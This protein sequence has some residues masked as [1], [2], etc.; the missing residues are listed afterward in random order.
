MFS[1]SCVHVH[2]YQI[3]LIKHKFKDE[4]VSE[5]NLMTVE[6]SIRRQPPN[7]W[8]HNLPNS[9]TLSYRFVTWGH[10]VVTRTIKLFQ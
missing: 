4:I 10:V 5:V 9:R 6:Q 8:V 1:I 3:S 7:P 2:G